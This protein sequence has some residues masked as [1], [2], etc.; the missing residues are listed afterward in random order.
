MNARPAT[1]DLRWALINALLSIAATLAG[2]HTG[3][4]FPTWVGGFFLGLSLAWVAVWA[5]TRKTEAA[6]R[7]ET[8]TATPPGLTVSE[9]G[10]VLN[11]QGVNYVPQR[12]ETTTDTTKENDR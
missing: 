11:W 5:A 3:A 10:S 7:T 9:D 12:A 4:T 8:T 6:G 1:T 2:I